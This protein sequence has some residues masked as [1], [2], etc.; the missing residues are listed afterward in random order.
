MKSNGTRYPVRATE[1][2]RRLYEGG[3]EIPAVLEALG[4]RGYFPSRSTCLYWCSPDA[5]DAHNARQKARLYPAA[6]RR[7]RELA[8]WAKFRRMRE[9]RGAGLSYDA[10]A[11]VMRL[12]F[13]L[14][15]VTADRARRMLGGGH[16]LST[17]STQALLEGENISRGRRGAR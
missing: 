11:K 7:S 17:E 1:F 15:F 3:H 2:A 10:V 5:K 4:R 16:A 9:L 14:E 12:D 13:G 8:W 6:R